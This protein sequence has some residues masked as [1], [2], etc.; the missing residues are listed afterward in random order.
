[1]LKQFNKNDSKKF[2]L[3][4]PYILITIL[5]VVIPLIFIFLKSV[6]S[7]T[8]SVTGEELPVA[9]N[10]NFIGKSVFEKIALS[11]GV[12]VACTVLCVVI[13]YLFAYF[14]SLSKHISLKIIAIALITSPMW[15]SMLVKLVGLKTLFDFI[16][17]ASNSTYGCIYTIIAL[18]YINLPIFILT[19]YTFI[20]SIP[21]NLLQASKDLGK[22]CIQTFFYVIVPYTK[23]AIFSGIAL[24]FLPS[25]TNAGVSQFMDNSNDGAMIG[26]DLL[27]QGLEGSASEIALARVSAL[28]LVICILL[29]IIWAVFVLIPKAIKTYRLNKKDGGH[30]NVKI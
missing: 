30:K 4:L 10:W 18:T 14:L 24:V 25:L 20:N 27:N 28:S 29:L 2:F 7:A 26:N 19:I 23:N 9:D 16:N 15:I 5:F 3:L 21:K 1:M 11:L 17:G 12:S 8:D 6:T 22:N 13:G